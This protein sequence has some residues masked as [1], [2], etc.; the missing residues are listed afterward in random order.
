MKIETLIKDGLIEDYCLGNAPSDAS[1]YLVEMMNTHPAL[2]A[3]VDEICCE[4]KNT[5]SSIKQKVSTSSKDVIIESIHQNRKI[6]NA[7]ALGQLEENITITRHLDIDLLEQLIEAYSPPSNF[8][9]IHLEPLYADDKSLFA[10]IWVKEFVPE[11]V[12]KEIDERF[13]VLEGKVNCYV[14]DM[15]FEMERGMYMKIPPQSDHRIEVTSQQPAKAI[16]SRV[17]LP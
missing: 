10:V 9:N 11:E 17:S 7:I 16:F 1:S 12:H 3:K 13:F 6:K 2:K 15:V 4:I 14:D 5:V 8:D